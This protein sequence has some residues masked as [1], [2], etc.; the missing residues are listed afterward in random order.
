MS[1]GSGLCRTEFQFGTTKVQLL[2]GDILNPGVDVAA[3]VSTDDNYL[4]MGS[5]V[6]ARLRQNA[7][8]VNYIRKAQAHCPVEAGEVIVTKAYAL[9]RLLGASYVLH[10]AV[11]DYD[12][13]A[14][15]LSD[16]VEQTTMKCL[17]RAA[18]L[19]VSTI[20]FPAFAT[21]A[22]NLSMEECARRMCSAIKVY[23]GHDRPLKD[24]YLMLYLPALTDPS[25][26]P[27]KRMEHKALNERFIREANL[28]LGV[29][30]DPTLRARQIRDFYGG[31]KVLQC[32][33]EIIT[34]KRDDASGKR[35]AVILGGPA[36]GKQSTLDYLHQRAQ[37]PG[38]LLGVGRRLVR[39][40]FGRVHEQTPTAFIYRKFLCALGKTE[41]GSDPDTK[42][43]LRELKRVYS[44]PHLNC[45]RFLDFLAGHRD[46]YPEIV[47][48]IDRLPNLLG[49]EG[50]A[51][52]AQ[53][54]DKKLAATPA[55]S[56]TERQPRPWAFWQ[57]LN[58]LGQQI[59]IVY[60]AR[61]EEFERLCQQRLTPYAPCFQR[62][63]E[64]VWLACI[65]DEEREQWVDELFRRYLDCQEGA[66]PFVHERY[67]AEAGCHPYLISLF[68]HLLIEAVK[69]AAFSNPDYAI[70][71]TEDAFRPIF[72][73]VCN[74]IDKPRREFFEQLIAL[75]TPTDLENLKKLAKAIAMD[76]E[77]QAL[78]PD[79]TKGDAKA[80]ARF[81]E[82]GAEGDPR[83][84][85]D[86]KTLGLLKDRGYL[87]ID[88]TQV[89]VAQADV[90]QT[91]QFMA[92]PFAAWVIDYFGLRH[93]REKAGQPTDL[94]ITLFNV[95]E[96][97]AAPVVRTMV[98][99]RGARVATAQKELNPDTKRDFLE[100]LGKCL[101]HLL[102]PCRYPDAGWWQDLEQAGNYILN[103]FTT[104]D[105]KRCLQNPHPGATIAFAV[106]EALK[107]I[108]W[109]LMLEATY[110]GEP[111]F[112][113]GRSIIGQQPN[114]IDE[115]IRTTDQVRALLIG[116]PTDDLPRARDEV[117]W[118]AA[119]LRQDG[120]F[121]V[122]PADL[123]MGSAQCQ[124]GPIL[125]ALGSRRYGLVHY[126]GHTHY[127]GYRSAWQLAAG[128]RLFTHELTSAL[129]MGP[130][131]FVFSSSCE[132]AV[133]GAV[134]PINYEDQTADLPS[135]FLQAG[136]EAYIGTLWRVE[137]EAA[138]RF[139]RR[140]YEAFLSGQANLG[141]CLRRAKWAGKQDEQHS[142]RINWLSF[143]LYGDPHLMLGDLFP[144]LRSKQ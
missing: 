13:D 30:Y 33:E 28:V 108:P 127:D 89:D 58:E 75:A 144:D 61:N 16:L 7:R 128:K 85:L 4:T 21:G 11:I 5:G 95:A 134:E 135:A 23:L 40:T 67:A 36:T 131:L 62:Q 56:V 97:P 99:G 1:T 129:Q 78:I 86:E 139:V 31:Q 103:Q 96:P 81:V 45:Q 27:A 64:E 37:Q 126:S 10:G 120:R 100:N 98:R 115:V 124:S 137:Q 3:V 53:E 143:V 91:V 74:A 14:L 133:G 101:N 52:V 68:G 105:I 49:M 20:L 44:D 57:D 122:E 42:C 140:F 25:V 12:T 29:P 71:Y 83:R 112:R 41:R 104:G 113:V 142:D 130:P 46:R 90:A 6:A 121:C 136:V 26:T 117:A 82:L 92:K 123:L 8:S 59:R 50:K 93:A 114:I 32:L 87:I 38:D 79:L 72:Q 84:L 39:L 70:A 15:P 47:Y 94:E 118:L 48:L 80:C 51:P 132:S 35:H 63:I 110:A 88:G 24:I 102:N 34:G 66:P 54:E 138:H 43:L 111:P 107:N 19:G 17:E 73:T 2:Q 116:D 9:Q 76:E 77:R 55:T 60:T 106:D 109:E 69:T 119:R 65:T 141:E 125:S 22:G 18:A